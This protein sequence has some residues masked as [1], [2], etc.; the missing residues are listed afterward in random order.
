MNGLGDVVNVLGIEPSDGNPAV[1]R[2]VDV[3][4]RGQTLR[5]VSIEA[6]ESEHTDLIGDVTPV[7]GGASF[8]QS[9]HQA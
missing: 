4:L 8:F 7:L 3:M 6:S 1:Q 5:L 9:R 2:E